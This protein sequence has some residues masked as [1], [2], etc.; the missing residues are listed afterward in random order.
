MNGG[1]ETGNFNGWTRSGDT[2]HTCVDNDQTFS[3]AGIPPHSP[4]WA[5]DL[6]TGSPFAF[7]Y[8]TQTLATTPGASYSL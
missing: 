8:L 2:L 4:S 5:A 6:G 1:F 7:G 3:C